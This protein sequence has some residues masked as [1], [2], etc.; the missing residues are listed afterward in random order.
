M[1]AI[2]KLFLGATLL[3]FTGSAIAQPPIRANVNAQ[4][5]ISANASSKATAAATK[6]AA[7]TTAAASHDGKVVRE[8]ARTNGALQA[9]AHANVNGKNHANENSVLTA[10]GETSTKVKHDDADKD[11]DAAV[12]TGKTKTGKPTKKEKKPH[13]EDGD[14]D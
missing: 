14:D 13:T 2:C 7:A 8:Q 9:N 4:T 3:F 5:R 12:K 6:A 11:D 1:K 10:S